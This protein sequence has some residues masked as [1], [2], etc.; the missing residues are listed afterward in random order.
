MK[1]LKVFDNFRI[2][3]SDT[4]SKKH[5]IVFRAYPNGFGDMHDSNDI[6]QWIEQNFT[7]IETLSKNLKD[8]NHNVGLVIFKWSDHHAG[9]N[10]DNVKGIDLYTSTYTGKQ[11]EG[12]TGFSVDEFKS[13]F[14]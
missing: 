14:C 1:Y 6:N 9:T 10:I 5:Y 2:N 3:E 11:P 7:D 8:F 12:I 13:K 4:H